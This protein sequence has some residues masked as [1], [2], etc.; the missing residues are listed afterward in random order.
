M[1]NTCCLIFCRYL[2][3][4]AINF[5]NFGTVV[6]YILLAAENIELLLSSLV[7]FSFCY[8]S[9]IVAVVVLPITWLG[10]P[11]EFW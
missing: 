4:V 6:V 9:I 1:K 7:G 3:T 10:T 11:K 5:T 2:V 8:I